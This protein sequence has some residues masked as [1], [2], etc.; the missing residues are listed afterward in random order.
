MLTAFS[1][2]TSLMR[3]IILAGEVEHGTFKDKYF[4]S[5][6]LILSKH[7]QELNADNMEL[8]TIPGILIGHI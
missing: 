1:G 4:N 2:P 5:C 8:E 7:S 3:L 6:P